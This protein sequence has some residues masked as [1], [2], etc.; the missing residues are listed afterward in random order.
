M[1]PKYYECGTLVTCIKSYEFICLTVSR[2][3]SQTASITLV[4]ASVAEVPV[5]LA[6]VATRFNLYSV[7]INGQDPKVCLFLDVSNMVLNFNQ[8]CRTYTGRV[9][10][11]EKQLKVA[12][13]SLQDP[14]E[15]VCTADMAYAGTRAAAQVNYTHLT[16]LVLHH[17]RGKTVNALTE[18]VQHGGGVKTMCSLCGGIHPEKLQFS[19]YLVPNGKRSW[20]ERKESNF[21][22]YI[23]LQFSTII[24][25]LDNG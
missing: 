8:I 7:L 19:P 24:S 12:V 13:K 21:S 22:P 2:L 1:T 25:V 15:L 20:F 10:K 4:M 6:S 23:T 9:P 11:V 16:R 14:N 3:R 17:T 18:H 5:T